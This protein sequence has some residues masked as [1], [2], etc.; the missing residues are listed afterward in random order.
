[1][2]RSSS[3]MTAQIKKASNTNDGVLA[4]ARVLGPD[5]DLPTESLA[6]A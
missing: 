3:F 6:L 1:M 5:S 2:R 4:P